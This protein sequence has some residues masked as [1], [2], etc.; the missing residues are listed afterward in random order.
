MQDDAIDIKS[1]MMASGKLKTK[2]K[3]GT[4]EPRHFKEQVGPSGSGKSPEENMDE[5]SKIIKYLSNKISRI[6]LDQEKYDTYT[7]N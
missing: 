2:T 3:M 4:K 7:R 1:N 6:E 5:M